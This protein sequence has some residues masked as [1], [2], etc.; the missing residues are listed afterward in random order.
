M[1]TER[2]QIIDAWDKAWHELVAPHVSINAC[3]LAARTGREVFRHFDIHAKVIAVNAIA[4]NATADALI[5]AGTPAAQWPPEAW[6]VGIDPANEGPGYSGHLILDLDGDL[7][8]Q[9]SNQFSRPEHDMPVAPCL[10]IDG[11]GPVLRQG[12][13]LHVVLDHGVH[14]EY[15]LAN[16]RRYTTANDWRIRWKEWTGP[17]IRHM[18]ATLT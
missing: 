14:L 2:E 11:G 9:T 15:R 4:V 8:D 7:L 3:I 1:T 13:Y 6:S 5:R 10:L 17:I 18:R 12:G 16:H